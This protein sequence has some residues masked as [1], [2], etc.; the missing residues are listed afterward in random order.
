M[1]GTGG[2][3]NTFQIDVGAMFVI[4]KSIQGAPSIYGLTLG[5]KLI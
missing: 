4:A 3:L 1:N 5:G 2:L